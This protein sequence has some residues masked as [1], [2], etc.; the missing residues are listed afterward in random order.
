MKKIL[1]MIIAIV[2]IVL[3]VGCSNNSNG[4]VSEYVAPKESNRQQ[5]T[6]R[7]TEATQAPTEALIEGI[8][9]KL[10]EYKPI[11]TFSN[12]LI[13]I[14]YNKNQK[15]L[16]NE[17]GKI[18]YSTDKDIETNPVMEGG[19]TFF[20]YK[21]DKLYTNKIIDKEGNETYTLEDTDDDTYKIWAQG[22]GVFLVS[23]QQSG[24]S[25]VKY[26]IYAVDSEGEIIG[27]EKEIKSQPDSVKHF[28]NNIFIVSFEGGSDR[29]FAFNSNSDSLFLLNGNYKCYPL[30]DGIGYFIGFIHNMNS[31]PTYHYFSGSILSNDLSSEESWENWLNNHSI[32]EDVYYNHGTYHESLEYIQEGFRLDKKDRNEVYIYGYDDKQT[33]LP[34]FPESTSIEKIG[35]FSG[36]YLPIFLKGADSKYYVTVVDTSGK[37]MYEPVKTSDSNW[38]SNSNY[39][40]SNGKVFISENKQYFLVD[41]SGKKNQLSINLSGNIEGY[42]GDYVYHSGGIWNLKDNSELTAYFPINS[43]AYSN[44]S[45]ESSDVSSAKQKNYVTK[46]DFSIIGKWKNIGEYTYGQAQTG[47]IINFDGTN[48]NFYSPKD[49]YAFYKKGDNYRLDCTSPLG[50]T[51]SFTVKIIDDDH[52]DVSNGSNI[53]E[54]KRV[55]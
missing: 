36:G 44:R 51:A 54:L 25:E 16:M 15:G 46:N 52:I 26:S 47:S 34:S 12:G 37:Q 43:N 6:E 55:S 39:F 20:C 11:D 50:D 18:V 27:T 41:T 21:E 1:S 32:E 48:C 19:Y 29:E 24:F 30:Y 14:E 40:C 3:L 4:T 8:G 23:H 9:E 35:V 28:G 13:W 45:D 49:T 42:D 7:V 33:K 10:S 31:N 2:M 22:D 38:F 5:E 17:N 53:V